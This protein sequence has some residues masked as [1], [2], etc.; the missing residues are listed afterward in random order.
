M[1]DDADADDAD[2]AYKDDDAGEDD[3]EKDDALTS[4]DGTSDSSPESPDEP[5]TL[6]INETGAGYGLLAL[7]GGIARLFLRIG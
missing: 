5:K 3:A 4:D 7:L 2:D 6:P 1:E